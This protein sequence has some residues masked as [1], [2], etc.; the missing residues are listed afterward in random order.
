M[1]A[2]RLELEQRVIELYLTK[3]IPEFP[4]EAL[5][6]MLAKK[7]KE[8]ILSVEAL[9]NDPDC[10]ARMRYMDL[11]AK[12]KAEV[13]DQKLQLRSKDQGKQLFDS[14]VKKGFCESSGS[15]QYY[16]TDNLSLDPNV[17]SDQ[18]LLLL[19]ATEDF[20][21]RRGEECNEK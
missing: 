17:L 2:K 3:Q 4:K 16:S 18:E 9:L 15:G 20:E 19:I 13:G 1:K 10:S 7:N 8:T 21:T 12:R 5:L 6:T 11:F 14:L